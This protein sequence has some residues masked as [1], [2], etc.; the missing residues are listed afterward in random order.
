MSFRAKFF[1]SEKADR[2]PNG[3]AQESSTVKLQPACGDEE[4]RDWSRWTP[5]GSI[6]LHIDQPAAFDAFNLG[7][8]YFVDFTPAP[9]EEA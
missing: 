5:S 3:T 4:N 7:Q 6:V 2:S 1:V 9:K 8:H